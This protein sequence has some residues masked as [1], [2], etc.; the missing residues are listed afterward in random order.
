MVDENRVR[1]DR[2]LANALD[3]LKSFG[4]SPSYDTPNGVS[5]DGILSKAKQMSSCEITLPLSADRAVAVSSIAAK[6]GDLYIPAYLT[7][8]EEFQNYLSSLDIANNTYEVAETLASKV[9][10]I[11]TRDEMLEEQGADYRFAD[12]LA[13]WLSSHQKSATGLFVN[14]NKVSYG[15]IKNFCSVA[16]VYNS[17]GKTIPD[18]DK[19]IVSILSHVRSGTEEIDEIYDICYHYKNM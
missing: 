5:G 19:A 15:A 10:L 4:A 11:L 13:S 12:V 17:L 18:A 1:R 6:N 3:I 9:N 7:T 8:K 2:D 14:K 16:K